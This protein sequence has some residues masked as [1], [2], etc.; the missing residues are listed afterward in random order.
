MIGYPLEQIYQ[1]VAY[2][3]YYF[4]WNPQ[5]ILTLDHR[6]RRRWVSEIAD[7]NQKLNLGT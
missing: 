3:A 5:S 1:E 6:F 4:H 7:I 2:I